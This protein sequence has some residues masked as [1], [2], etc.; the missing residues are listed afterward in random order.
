[1]QVT[2]QTKAESKRQQQEE[3]L[4][5]TGAERFFRF[6]EMSRAINKI[7]PVK[8]RLAFEERNKGNFLLI[9]KDLKDDEV[10]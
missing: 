1:M 7:M 3:F 8:N 2:F 5:L 10:G 6:L 9:H 4:K